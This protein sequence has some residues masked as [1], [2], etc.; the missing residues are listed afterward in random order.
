M[1]PNPVPTPMS[2][3][4]RMLLPTILVGFGGGVLMFGSLATWASRAPL[5]SAA[6]ASGNVSPDSSRKT[7]QHLE[8]GIL[9]E[10][11]VSEGS[12]VKK[13]DML[14][15]LE[16]ILARAQFQAKR[17]QWFR[18][19]II[20]A[21]LEAHSADAATFV[22]PTLANHRIDGNLKAFIA[23]QLALFK[24]RRGSFLE[25]D[26]IYRQQIAQ[27]KQ[28]SEAKMRENESLLKQRA[29]LEEEIADKKEL[30]A[31]SLARKP[32]WLALERARAEV[33]GRTD[34]NIAELARISERT[35]E[36]E[37]SIVTNRTGFQQEISDHL[38]KTNT[39]IS[40]LEETLPAS[41][42]ILR[43]TDIVAPVDGTILNMRFKTVGGVVRPGEAVVDLV[44]ANEDL[45]IDAKLSPNDID[46]VRLGLPAEIYLT[47]YVSRYAPRLMGTVTRVGADIV[48]EPGAG[49]A[50][51]PYFEIRV[52]IERSELK[53]AGSPAMTPGMPA[54]V[55]VL[56]GTRT[57]AQY[58]LDPIVKS[59][60]RA[61][62]E[63]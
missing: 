61:L 19:Q 43:R 1:D 24:A 41:E 51:P 23:A 49:S 28:Q 27:L 50:T 35:G 16:P 60:R 11:K 48:R 14:F 34:A 18:L 31:K 44:P 9:R 54:E 38:V 10:I 20:R 53:R 7:I 63:D 36:I 3:L 21:R 13:G 32:E 15:T 22:P 45:Y 12:K 2:K 30:I 62:R 46:V 42:D 8:G 17:Q 33:M 5:A 40:Q 57:F 47:P 55:Y 26:Q 37:L 29:F 58:L 59:F 25:R 39:D 52:K 4:R 56:T 6:I